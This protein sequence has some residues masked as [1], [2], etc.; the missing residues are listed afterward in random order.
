[1]AQQL[2][3]ENNSALQGEVLQTEGL[4]D[5][6]RDQLANASDSFRRS[7]E[8]ARQHGNKFLQASDL[9]NLGTVALHYEEYD[10]ALG[11]FEDASQ[12]AQIDWGAIGVGVGAGQCRVGLLQAG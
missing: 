10:E 8:F 2:S 11:S 12:I 7:L 4:I 5:F 3:K 1:M 6:H 9:L